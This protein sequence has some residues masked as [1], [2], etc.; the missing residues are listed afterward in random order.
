[1]F[2]PKVSDVFRRTET[3]GPDKTDPAFDFFPDQLVIV[4]EVSPGINATC[5]MLDNG[6]CYQH[7]TTIGIPLKY[8]T[9]EYF[10]RVQVSN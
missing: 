10:E 6:P 1:M 5:V 3:R 7:G 2:E 9:E 8:F 4:K